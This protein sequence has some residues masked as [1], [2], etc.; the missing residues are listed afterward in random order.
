MSGIKIDLFGKKYFFKHFSNLNTKLHVGYFL[1]FW[2]LPFFL[3]Y[4]IFL[5]KN[6][7][8]GEKSHFFTLFGIYFEKKGKIQKTKKYPT[9]SFVLRFEKCKK[10]YFFPK[11]SIF[12][13][14]KKNNVKKQVFYDFLKNPWFLWKSDAIF[15]IL[16]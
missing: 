15:G 16:E 10:K 9:W 5:P 12:M 6:Q 1:V 8:F 11:R 7:H 3:E 14:D 4:F 2:I 13:P